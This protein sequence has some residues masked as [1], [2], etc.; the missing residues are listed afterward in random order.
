MVLSGPCASTGGCVTSPNHPNNYSNSESCEILAP[1]EPLYF[2]QFATEEGRDVLT[3]DGQ[4]YSGSAG[5]PQGATTSLMILWNCDVANTFSGWQ[6]CTAYELTLV[7]CKP[8]F[9]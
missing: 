3:F 1:E 9:T 5:P 2:T 8:N 6:I 4:A 7:F